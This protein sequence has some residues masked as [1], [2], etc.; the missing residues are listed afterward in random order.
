MSID[1]SDGVIGGEDGL[2][3]CV[4]VVSHQNLKDLERIL[5]AHIVF[6]LVL[7]H[8]GSGPLVT[9]AYRRG[10][11]DSCHG[12]LYFGHVIFVPPSTQIFTDESRTG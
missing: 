5:S 10:V 9:I 4:K 3:V 8:R 11:P 7:L 12:D 2:S 6:L 1:I